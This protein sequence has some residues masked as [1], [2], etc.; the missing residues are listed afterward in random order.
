MKRI[1]AVTLALLLAPSFALAQ[2]SSGGGASPTGSASTLPFP[3]FHF[4]GNV[5]RTIEESDPPEFPQPVRPPKGAPNIV[6]H[7]D[8]RRR[9][10]A[11]RHVRRAGADAG[12]RSARGR[13]AALHA[14]PHDGPVLADA[15]RAADGA[16]PPLHRQRRDHRGRDRLRRLHRHHRQE[17]G[18]DRRGAARSTATRPRGS[19]RTTTRPTGRRARSAR[20]IAGRAGWASTTS[21]ASWAATWTSGSRRCTRTTSS[22]RARPIPTTS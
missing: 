19:A 22:C 5:G 21:T 4:K 14:L 7:P 2:A 15:R 12:P 9:L 10:R 18:H 16:Q 20:S 11:V 8:R 1:V 3:D 6:Y 13:G 17:R